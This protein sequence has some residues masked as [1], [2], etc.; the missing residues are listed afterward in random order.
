MLQQQTCKVTVY[1]EAHCLTKI[2][3]CF[4]YRHGFLPFHNRGKDRPGPA[5]SLSLP[6]EGWDVKW[7]QGQNKTYDIAEHEKCC[8]ATKAGQAQAPYKL[9]SFCRA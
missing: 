2:C 7:L 5:A 1:R 9:V 6:C 3:L 4:C 8:R